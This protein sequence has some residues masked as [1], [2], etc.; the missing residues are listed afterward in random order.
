MDA[1]RLQYHF[2]KSP[3]GILAWDVRKLIRFAQSI[4]AEE[5]SL[6]SIKEVD[7]SYWYELGGLGLNPSFCP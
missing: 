6:S 5:V 4:Q 1:I 2:R 7:E 3:G